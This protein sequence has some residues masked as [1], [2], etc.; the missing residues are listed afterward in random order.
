MRDC[1]FS[2]YL[3]DTPL[4]SNR[5]VPDLIWML[6]S[7][8]LMLNSKI[9]MVRISVMSIR[10]LI[11][12]LILVTSLEFHFWSQILVWIANRFLPRTSDTSY[13][14]AWCKKSRKCRIFFCYTNQHHFGQISKLYDIIDIYFPK[15]EVDKSWQSTPRGLSFPR[16]GISYTAFHHIWWLLFWNLMS[17][18]IEFYIPF[19]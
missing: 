3:L 8:I 5:F 7:R 9:L 10:I 16:G 14:W 17:V 12:S 4:S 19:W 2:H 15:G 6:R 1:S 11:I 18:G 13:T